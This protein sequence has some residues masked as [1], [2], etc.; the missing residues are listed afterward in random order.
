MFRV[1]FF[2]AITRTVPGLSRRMLVAK[3]NYA[4]HDSY[5]MTADATYFTR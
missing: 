5:C 2:K 4:F 3:V 1:G